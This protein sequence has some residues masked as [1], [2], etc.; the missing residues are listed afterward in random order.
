MAEYILV[1]L[2]T[3]QWLEQEVLPEALN[4]DYEKVKM[5]LRVLS[6]AVEQGVPLPQKLAGFLAVA[7]RDIAH[8]GNPGKAFGIK[9]KRGERDT[10]EAIE[11]AVSRVCKIKF[12]RRHNPN[13]SI[14][15]AIAQVAE[16]EGASEETV[17]AAW[18]DYRNSVILS[19]DGR[20]AH[21]FYGK[22][23]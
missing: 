21:V 10:S 8:G 1:T 2:E 22:V 19:A 13:M 11:R 7:L 15:V 3:L 16:E 14:E 9:R 23:K 18:R 17:K 5:V 4:S 6:H 20:G 12:I